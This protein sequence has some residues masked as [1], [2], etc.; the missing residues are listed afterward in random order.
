MKKKKEKISCILCLYNEHENLDL[1]KLNFQILKGNE[2][3]VLDGGSD[4]GTKE[5]L[6]NLKFIK[7]IT[8][9]GTGRLHRIIHGMRIAKNR[10]C[11]VYLADDDF[12]K[13][14]VEKLINELIESKKQGL[15]IRC[16]HKKSDSYLEG[17]WDAYTF[18]VNL[19]YR[20]T[21]V[22]GRPC[23]TYKKYFENLNVPLKDFAADDSFLTKEFERRKIYMKYGVSSQYI[24]RKSSINTMK[25]IFLRHFEY[26]KG[27]KISVKN[28]KD[29]FNYIFHYL[30]RISIYRSILMILNGYIK[31]APM[32]FVL[33]IVR[34]IGFIL[35]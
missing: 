12:S 25:L 11:L 17:W 28:P 18:V 30:V 4:D 20:N 32:T 34:F 29:Y 31:Y 22:L 27:D 7:F 26:G 23:I 8:M 2:I 35:N 21:K 33:G 9:P 14:N 13:L 3:I 10:I 15:N 16:K 6:K 5:A 24:F 19:S 1:I